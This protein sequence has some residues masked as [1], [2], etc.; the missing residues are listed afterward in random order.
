MSAIH[1]D[2]RTMQ[3]TACSAAHFTGKE[4]DDNETG[5]DYLG[6]DIIPISS[7]DSSHRIGRRRQRPSLM[8]ISATR[9][10]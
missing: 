7:D 3:F 8:P 4:R 9:K 6:L 1:W 2:T 5:L 10:A